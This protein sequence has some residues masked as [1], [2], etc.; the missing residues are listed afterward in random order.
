MIRSLWIVVGLAVLSLQIHGA[1]QSKSKEAQPSKLKMSFVKVKPGQF[2]MGCS[3]GDVEC[4]PDEKPAHKVRITKAFEIG[5]YEVSQEEWQ[6]VTQIKQLAGL[7]TIPVE[8]IDWNDVQ[9]FMQKLNDRHDGYHYRL[10]TEAEWEYAARGGTD[11]PHA[12]P[13][14]LNAW[15]RENADGS[16]HLVGKRMTNFFGL[17]DTEGNAA[18]WV[19]DWYDPAYYESSP[20]EDPQ[21]PP[22]G[23]RHVVRGGSWNSSLRETRVSARGSQS[24]NDHS[25]TTGLRV[26]R[27]P[28]AP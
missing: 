18:E 3:K 9:S 5:R 23:E 25:I 17:Y 11:T 20:A 22:S 7:P 27:E 21:G 14:D 24:E 26:V 28:I 15:H 4:A 13:G 12:V 16:P 8:G 19:Q 2:T 6:E 10:P 1:E